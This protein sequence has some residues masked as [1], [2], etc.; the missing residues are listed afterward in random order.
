MSEFVDHIKP[1]TLEEIGQA[2][3]ELFDK[4]WWVRHEAIGRPQMGQDAARRIEQKYGIHN[5]SC[6]SDYEWGMLKGKLSALRWVL[7]DEWDNFDT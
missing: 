5:L 1:R 7:G 4:C 3:N 2:E 6:K